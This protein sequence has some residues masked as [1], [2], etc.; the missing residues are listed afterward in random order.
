M[1]VTVE[2]VNAQPV[3]TL[4]APGPQG[5]KGDVGDVNP[6]MPIILSATEDARD[7]AL[8]AQAGSESARDD[9]Q[10]AQAQT[11]LDAIATAADRVQTGLDRT[12]TAADAIAT[13]ADRVQT[14]LD[15]VATAADRAQTGLDAG[16]ATAKAG[17]ATTQAGIATTKAGDALASANAAAGHAD[18]ATTQAGIA[19]TQAG[20]ATT[21]AGDA[22]GYA[23]TA[24]TQA[25]IA[26]TQAGIATTQAGTATTQ[27]GIATTQAGIATT[28]ANNAAASYDAFDDRYLGAKSSAPTVD[29]DG[30][31]L[32]T[33]A[34]YWDTTL[35][36]L[37][38]WTG[39]AWTNTTE[40]DARVLADTQLLQG[41]V[42][43]TDM[44]LQAIREGI[45]A[46]AGLN[47]SIAAVNATVLTYDSSI[48]LAIY[49]L[50]ALADLAGVVARAISGGD[51]NLRAGTADAPSLAPLGDLNTGLFFPAADTMAAATNGL[52]RWRTDSSGRTGFG[53]N[54][55]SCIVDIN[56][57]HLRV[58]TAKTPATAGA[59]G[60]AGDISWDS[61]YVYV[62]VAANT[63]KRAALTTW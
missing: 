49:Q 38:V 55:P 32:L 26:T 8:A 50:T 17:E 27:A 56:D 51:I 29:N 44:A 41:I 19:T 6:Q 57:D 24:T 2:I 42:Y 13:A 43:A 20:I 21:K 36:A 28:Q 40:L 10:A 11:A 48:T 62:C 1:N 35:Q 63:W 47:T 23:T 61:S 16:T 7:A 12:A 5:A 52:E 30:Q 3:V 4:T 46:E 25:G 45:R 33:G 18:T 9:A 54:A 39:S 58:R 37:R 14:G 53:T 31:A 34:L 15:A 59:A 22:S 60:N